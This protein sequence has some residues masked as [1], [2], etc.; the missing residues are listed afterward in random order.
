MAMMAA[1]NMNQLCES[2]FFSCA[3]MNPMKIFEHRIETIPDVPENKFTRDVY[4]STNEL[5]NGDLDT[6]AN[7]KRNHDLLCLIQDI[8]DGLPKLAEVKKQ[9]LTVPVFDEIEVQDDDT[10]EIKKFI[11]KANYEFIG[12]YCNH[13]VSDEKCDKFA[14]NALDVVSSEEF[15]RYEQLLDDL[16]ATVSSIRHADQKA[17][18]AFEQVHMIPQTS[19]VEGVISDL[20]T[21]NK[22]IMEYNST[23]NPSCSKCTAYERKYEYVLK[24]VARMREDEGIIRQ[25]KQQLE[26]SQDQQQKPET[27]SEFITKRFAGINKFKLTDVKESYKKLFNITKTLSVIKSEIEAMGG[28]KVSN[29]S[30]ILWS[31]RL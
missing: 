7:V 14:S 2:R 1:S 30:G 20:L 17:N 8:V 21:L 28:F 10:Q 5:V 23:M 3:C 24:E 11:R 13:K 22:K 12:Y 27:I 26:S 29:V 15:K 9:K 18:K 31:T 19:R 6:T 4:T 25:R 16:S